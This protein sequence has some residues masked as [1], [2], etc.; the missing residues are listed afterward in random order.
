LA[1]DS[2]GR[3]CIASTAFLTVTDALDTLLGTKGAT[4]IFGEG[5]F[6]VG[7]GSIVY[8]ENRHYIGSGTKDDTGTTNGTTIRRTTDNPIFVS[9]A[10]SQQ[11]HIS[12]RNMRL[13]GAGVADGFTTPLLN[14]SYVANVIIEHVTFGYSQSDG[15]Y[16]DDASFWVTLKNCQAQMIDG[17]LVKTS[18]DGGTTLNIENCM[19]HY[20]VGLAYLYGVKTFNIVGGGG[21]NLSG[22][23][24]SASLSTGVIQGV[25]I[26][27]SSAS[28]STGNGI[29]LKLASVSV[30]GNR[31]LYYGSGYTYAPIL[32][33]GNCA[34]TVIQG[35][36]FEN[37]KGS[38][39]IVL[40]ADAA[41]FMVT[42]NKFSITSAS[43]IYS[44][45]GKTGLILRSNSGYITENSGNATGTGAQQTIAHGCKF[46]PT[47]NQV[48]LSERSTGGALAYM[49]A[50]PDAT[51]IYVTATNATDFTW[52]VKY[53]P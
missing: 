10:A 52:Q 31:I 34:G 12:F 27:G 13:N 33:S 8:Y 18:N 51:N 41:N 39:D 35:N 46:T 9:G 5:T 19:A 23:V 44:I 15:A 3:I 32:V 21:D 30:F 26:E 29:T 43:A 45:A 49:S 37:T 50:A 25:D 1:Q 16:L 6:V 14:L 24:I 20:C 11:R 47:Y 4:I 22:D 40:A 7:D 2:E 42:G 36:A 17:F 28:G 48:V 38:I 53:N